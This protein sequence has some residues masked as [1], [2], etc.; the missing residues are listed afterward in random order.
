MAPNRD[1]D[2]VVAADRAGRLARRLLP[3]DLDRDG[4]EDGGL[5]ARASSERP[6]ACS[7]LRRRP[8]QAAVADRKADGLSELGV[9]SAVAPEAGA[10]EADAIVASCRSL[11][12]T[13]PRSVATLWSAVMR[14]R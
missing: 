3:I 5:V 12:G 9:G 11:T 7:R 1:V 14:T 4:F 6:S 10:V 8:G 13:S 2:V